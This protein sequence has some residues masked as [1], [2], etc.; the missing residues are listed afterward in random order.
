VPKSLKTDNGDF[1]KLNPYPLPSK[2]QSSHS[3]TVDTEMI[4]ATRLELRYSKDEILRLHASHAPFGGN[5]VG[6]EAASWRYFHKS[7]HL[8]ST[9]EA[10]MLAVLP[11]APSL[12]HISRNRGALLAKRNRLLKK[13][14]EEGLITK[15][16]YELSILESI[17]DKPYPLPSIAPHFVEYVHTKLPQQTTQSTV[18]SEVQKMINQVADF[19]HRQYLQSD[20]HNMARAICRYDPGTKKLRQCSKTPT[21]CSPHRQG[22]A[23]ATGPNQRHSHTNKW[24]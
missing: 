6:L 4:L 5:V 1:L 3:K 19:H 10:A 11:N 18:S 20:I 9:A 22:R 17:P 23:H 2:T 13:M 16:D 14:M 8:L 24:I 7:S 12:I 15:D 21:P